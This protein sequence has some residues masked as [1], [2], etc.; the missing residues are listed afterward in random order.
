[1]KLTPGFYGSPRYEYWKV[2]IDFN[3]DGDYSDAGENILS[4]VDNEMISRIIEIPTTVE[5]CRTRMRVVMSP[6]GEP[7]AFR[8][9]YHGEPEDYTVYLISSDY[10]PSWAED[11]YYEWIENVLLNDID[12]QSEDRCYSNFLHISTELQAGHSYFVRLTLGFSGSSYDEYWNVWIDF[13]QDNVFQPEENVL[14][15]H[16]TGH[17]DGVV[18]I[19]SELEDLPYKTRMRISMRWN[20]YPSFEGGYVYG[21]VEDYTIILTE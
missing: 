10:E 7:P 19:P 17:I 5:P 2:W 3:C 15:E 4:Q 20:Q 1:M 16:N 9:F 11:Q 21:E 6:D 12:N 8:A 13:N 14:S 18:E